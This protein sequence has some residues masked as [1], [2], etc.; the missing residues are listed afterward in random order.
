M[1]AFLTIAAAF[2]LI[3]AIL[4]MAV[5][6]RIFANQETYTGLFLFVALIMA[7]PFTRQNHHYSRRSSSVIL[8]FW[9]IYLLAV[10]L[11]IHTIIL[12]DIRSLSLIAKVSF[13]M[14]MAA[15]GF[16]LIAYGFECLCPERPGKDGYQPVG[17]GE[18]NDSK[19]E[20]FNESPMMAANMYSRLTFSWLTPML[21]LGTKKFLGEEDMWTLPPSD[22]AESLG[23]R[24]AFTW[25]RQQAIA[26]S[27][28]S[29][30]SKA[31][32][33]IALAQA[34]GGPFA[35]AGF[36]KLIYDCLAFVQPQ[37][38]RMLLRFVESYRTEKPMPPAA[39]FGIAIL[40]FVSANV[41]TAVLHQ[42]FDRCFA[43][44]KLPSQLLLITLSYACPKRSSNSDL[45]EISHSQQR[46]A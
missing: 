15:I 12:Q 36:L 9:P 29:K 11:R 14:W 35:M 43:T 16:G 2:A 45:P 33:K 46:R 5:A 40:M 17:D 38:L 39:G 18:D 27:P 19:E 13:G 21:Q 24:V 41:G 26:K 22:S 7:I 37:L 6:P 30:K 42:Y 10:A 32:L 20:L 1:Q 8:S 34:F 44:S 31:N 3:H 4:T 28:S 23:S 25:A